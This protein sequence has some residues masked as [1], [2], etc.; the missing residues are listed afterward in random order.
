MS[1]AGRTQEDANRY[2]LSRRQSVPQEELNPGEYMQTYRGKGYGDLFHVVLKCPSCNA[3]IGVGRRTHT[4]DLDGNAD[5]YCSCPM[6]PCVFSALFF[7][8]D[9]VPEAEG[10]A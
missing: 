6:K 4:I 5:I 2:P 3:L 1:D 9:W 8:N 7:M 10:S